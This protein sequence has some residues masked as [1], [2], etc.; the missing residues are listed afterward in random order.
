MCLY[1]PPSPPSPPAHLALYSLLVR[2]QYVSSLVLERAA[3]MRFTCCKMYVRRSPAALSARFL[4]GCSLSP[5]GKQF[6]FPWWDPD[7]KAR[8]E[9][10]CGWWNTTDTLAIPEPWQRFSKADKERIKWI[11]LRLPQSHGEYPPEWGAEPFPPSRGKFSSA[12]RDFFARDHPMW[13]HVDQEDDPGT[14]H[15]S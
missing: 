2:H 5:R 12:I 10:A 3:T 15:E 11:E 8:H 6:A 9:R 1:T 13:P 4:V 14:S 7:W